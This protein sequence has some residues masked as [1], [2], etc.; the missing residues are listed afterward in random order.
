VCRH[1]EQR[2]REIPTGERNFSLDAFSTWRSRA[3]SWTSCDRLQ[4][5][6][7]FA[8]GVIA[9]NGAVIHFP[10]GGHTSPL[11]PGLRAS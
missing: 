11:A 6:L 9:E 7:R 2:T 4:A 10:D 1:G 5:I 3:A 8:D